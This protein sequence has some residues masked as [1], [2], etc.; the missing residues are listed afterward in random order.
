MNIVSIIE[1]VLGLLNGVLSQ[2][3]IANGL[4]QQIITDVEAAIA[5][6]QRVQNTPVTFAQLEGL[7]A[8]PAW[9]SAPAAP[10]DSAPPSAPPTT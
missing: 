3:K 7:R 4:P 8:N 10:T 5:A 2:T 9:T 6:L 1:V